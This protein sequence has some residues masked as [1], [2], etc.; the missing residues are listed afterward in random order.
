[1]LIVTEGSKTEP[2]YFRTLIGELGLTTAQVKITG[3]GGSA[4]ISVV[5]EAQHILKADDDY[6]FICLVFDRDRHD[7]YDPALK[8]IAQMRAQKAF[9]A[10]TILAITSV[11]C[12]EVW[13]LAHVSDSRKPYDAAAPGGSPAK[14]MIK[15]LKKA[16]PCFEDYDKANCSP[17]YD[18]LRRNRDTAKRRATKLLQEA[19][20][21]RQPT[22]HENPSTRAHNL[23]RVLETLAEEQKES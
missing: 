9:K 19:E 17:F 5:E 16:D 2:S 10:K 12:F 21:E 14:A 3:E 1:M 7:T 11:P 13:Y 8:I 4:P 15:D 20:K 18:A 22:H 6:E 23:I